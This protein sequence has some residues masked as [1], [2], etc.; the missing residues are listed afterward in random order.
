MC[1]RTIREGDT[2]AS[3]DLCPARIVS[4]E[5]STSENEPTLLRSH[6]Y[7]SVVKERY[8]KI[9]QEDL[10]KKVELWKA[11]SPDDKFEF[12]PNATYSEEEERP[13]NGDGG[14]GTDNEQEDDE[15]VKTST[16]GLLFVP[17]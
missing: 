4:R 8:F 10:Q 13:E 6:I 15:M 7:K 9:D 17:K 2:Q 16:K 1:R 5:T 11:G 12:H 14:N 3:E